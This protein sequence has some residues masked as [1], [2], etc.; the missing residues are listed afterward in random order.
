MNKQ[1]IIQ[2]VV[3]LALLVSISCLSYWQGQWDGMRDLCP[4]PNTLVVNRT[5]GVLCY[6]P[7]MIEQIQPE[8]MAG[9]DLE[10]YYGS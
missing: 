5:N 7:E 10:E 4:E 9:F 1:D 2:G 8:P 6:T 3:V